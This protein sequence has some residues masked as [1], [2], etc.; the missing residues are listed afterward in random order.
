MYEKC[1]AT[2][3]YRRK[4]HRNV[5]LNFKF[6]WTVLS[7]FSMSNHH[8][9]FVLTS[10][11]DYYHIPRRI[12]NHPIHVYK[13]TN[14]YNEE[15]WKLPCKQV[16]FVEINVHIKSNLDY[17]FS[18]CTTQCSSNPFN[19]SFFIINTKKNRKTKH[20]L[21]TEI[22]NNDTIVDD[23]ILIP[24]RWHKRNVKWK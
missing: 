24:S 1:Y 9:I 8:H 13:Y 16:L 3:D 23:N 18:K 10:R 2:L 21:K 5:R 20:F 4:D 12:R 11:S 6:L 7:H 19:P 22:I 15:I 14:K 17:L